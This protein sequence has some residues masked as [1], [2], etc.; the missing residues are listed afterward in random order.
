MNP[1]GLRYDQLREK[2]IDPAPKHYERGSSPSDSPA[3]SCLLRTQ[4]VAIQQ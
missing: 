4:T 1:H 2:G 3:G